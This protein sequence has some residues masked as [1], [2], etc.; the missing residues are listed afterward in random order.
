MKTDL[1]EKIKDEINSGEIKILPKSHFIWKTILLAISLAIAFLS[2]V[3]FVSL[4]VFML[5]REGPPSPQF[6][7]ALI[8]ID[9]LPLFIILFALV[10]VLI[11]EYLFKKYSFAYRLPT[12]Y[13]LLFVIF[14]I[15]ISSLVVDRIKLHDHVYRLLKNNKFE[16][17]NFIYKRPFFRGNRVIEDKGILME[18]EDK[19]EGKIESGNIFIINSSS[20]SYNR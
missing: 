14:A 19:F 10:G 4:F 20:S 7:K 15:L 12:I 6:F 1:I 5:R 9:T 13:T 17:M 18:I 2:M 8:N 11:V 3:Y 16:N